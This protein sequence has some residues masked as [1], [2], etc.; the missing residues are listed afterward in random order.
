MTW[1]TFTPASPSDGVPAAKFGIAIGIAWV[2]PGTTSSRCCPCA[3]SPPGRI[4][5]DTANAPAE[6]VKARRDISD[7]R[8][9]SGLPRNKSNMLVSLVME[10]E[11]KHLPLGIFRLRQHGVWLTSNDSPTGPLENCTLADI[12]RLDFDKRRRWKRNG[13]LK[14]KRD[15]NLQIV[16]IEPAAVALP[17]IMNPADKRGKVTCRQRCRGSLGRS[18][19]RGRIQRVAGKRLSGRSLLLDQR[20][21][22]FPVEYV[23]AFLDRWRRRRLGCR[24]RCRP[25]GFFFFQSLRDRID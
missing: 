17:A 25:L 7:D 16:F 23:F 5:P 18:E 9:G 19:R 3:A 12:A 20:R 13:G 8:P 6:N 10:Q 11:G 4:I 21:D 15:R 2:P 1:A 24:L 14:R 22:G